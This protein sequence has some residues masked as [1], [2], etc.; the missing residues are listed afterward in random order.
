MKLDQ[1]ITELRDYI[2]A[3]NYKG[4]DPYDALNSPVLSALTFKNKYLRIAYIQ[5]LKKLPINIR[6]LLGIKKGCNPKGLGLILRGY[7]KLCKV[8]KKPE[9]LEKI[10]S[11]LDLLDGLKS[12]YCSGN[13]WGYNFDWQSRAFFVPKFTPTVVNSS[14]IGHALLD[15]YLLA[16]NERALN[17]ALPVADFILSDLNRLEENGAIC[18][19]YTPIDR[20]FVH[21]A[22]LMGA[23]FLT[24]LNR[25]AKRT[26]LKEVALKALKYSM[27]HQHD[28][29]SW[30]YSEKET[31]HWIDSFHTGFNLQAIKH[32]LDEGEA[33][34]YRTAFTKGVQ[35]YVNKFFLD[36]GTP[37]YYHDSV[38][39]IDIHSPAQALAFFSGMGEEYSKLTRKIMDWTFA[40]MRDDTGYFYFQKHKHGMN[41]IPYMRWAQAWMFN[42]LT[43]VFVESTR[44]ES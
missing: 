35:F 4:Y 5:G 41:K 30:F 2:E 14:F 39:P 11:I 13:G 7:A 43:S 31:S 21:N 24:R 28:D 29:G 10:D 22:N 15:A 34:E 17:M 42:A 1:A 40:N 19:S 26:E 12:K 25:F 36:D 16:S 27:R 9:Y 6:P 18:F 32:F 3:Q 37:K 44:K 33:E 38:N 23:S 20:Y 8:D